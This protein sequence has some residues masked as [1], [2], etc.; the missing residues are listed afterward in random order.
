M[1]QQVL[2]TVAVLTF[3]VGA[4]TD[5][6][7]SSHK[8]G[9]SG[10]HARNLHTVRSAEDWRQNDTRGGFIDLGPLG[11]TAACGSYRH[12]QGYCGQGYSIPAW[13]Y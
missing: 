3:A 8:T 2:A 7:A 11:F 13:T 12:K 5:A 4:T 9:H 1:R 6:M 10:R